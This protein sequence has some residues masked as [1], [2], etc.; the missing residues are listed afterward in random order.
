M[1]CREKLPD[2]GVYGKPLG[3]CEV[4]EYIMGAKAQSLKETQGCR[5]G[6]SQ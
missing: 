2:V 3:K 4:A 5:E 6:R 1:R